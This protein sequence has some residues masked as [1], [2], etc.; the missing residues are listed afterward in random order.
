MARAVRKQYTKRLRFFQNKVTLICFVLLFI[1]IISTIFAPLIAPYEFDST[2][3]LARKSPPSAK[4][5]LGTD[6]VGRDIFTRLLYGGRVSLLVGLCTMTLQ[7]VLGSLLGT[8]AGYCGGLTDRFLSSIA[9]AILCFPFFLLAMSMVTILG[10]GIYNIVLIIGLLMWPKLFRLIRTQVQSL[11]DNDYIT[12]GRAMGLST[13]EILKLH[14]IPNV[15]PTMTVAATLALAQ[16]I[17]LE[18]ALSFL[19]L[20]VQ[21]PMA[22]WGNML[23]EANNVSTLSTYWWMW[24]PPGVAVTITVICINYIGEGL[25][26][27]YDPKA[28]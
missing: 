1:I 19:S 24:L 7:I 13:W 9:D 17:I 2:D 14:L 3:L 26:R 25:R 6:S 22:S 28:I 11:K 12:A 21:P 27:A 16:G 4:H 20:G 8:L 10:S 5:W 23:A 15:I 18:A